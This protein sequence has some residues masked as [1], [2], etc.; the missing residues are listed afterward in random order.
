[1]AAEDITSLLEY[2][3]ST[4]LGGDSDDDLPQEAKTQ[5]TQGLETVL[6]RAKE[7]RQPESL[8]DLLAITQKLATGSRDASWR[9]PIGDS[10]ILD[11]CLDLLAE[12]ETHQSLKIQA[13]R[14][15]GNSCA[16]TDENRAR[17]VDGAYFLPI[18]KLLAEDELVPFVIPSLHNICIEYEPAH[19]KA[20]EAGLCKE[21]AA[22]LQSQRVAKA[23]HL[24]GIAAKTIGLLA[25]TEHEKASSDTSIPITLLQCASS[26]QPWPAPNSP[27]DMEDFIS[28]ISA[29]TAYLT[30]DRIATASASPSDS[31]AIYKSL[32]TA[33]TRF[34]FTDAD[35]DDLDDA[36]QLIN[37]RKALVGIVA[38]LS[39]QPSWTESFSISSDGNPAEWLADHGVTTDWLSKHHSP[40]QEAACLTFG[41]L[42]CDDAKTS[43]LVGTLGI[44]KPLISLL[45]KEYPFQ[46][47][48]DDA[49]PGAVLHSAIGLLKNLA[50]PLGNRPVLGE[51]LLSTVDKPIGDS[52]E[53]STTGL[54]PFI[55]AHKDTQPQTQ[56]A[57]ISLC[58]LLLTGTPSN[59]RLFCEPLPTAASP[60]NT[61]NQPRTQ[62]HALIDVF[63]TAPTE[64]TKTEASRAALALCRVL[65]GSSGGPETTILTSPAWQ[66]PT[67]SSG[68]LANFLAR[69]DGIHDLLAFLLTQTRF[70]A[71]RSEAWFVLALTTRHGSDG[72]PLVARALTSSDEA[73]AAL[74]RAVSLGQ[75]QAAAEAAR[76]TEE[77]K[78]KQ[79]ATVDG[80]EGLGLEPKQAD[81]RQ[82]PQM[83]KIDRENVLVLLVEL[84]KSQAA[85]KVLSEEHKT[86]LQQLMQT[87]GE[88]VLGEREQPEVDA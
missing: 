73:L 11:F 35:E 8:D 85:L 83:A 16:D 10:G 74:E 65:H 22:W 63:T 58:R 67:T 87:G 62:L 39:S 78:Q 88:M 51:Q 56:L 37:M 75:G 24:V 12:P 36:N 60:D 1:M 86:R 41:N 9:I 13:L 28:L 57:T 66:E 4:K 26:P 40:L 2:M 69:H 29:A 14:L 19:A 31:L 18:I 7:L 59:A 68:P 6:A 53:T 30:A 17:V 80:I 20:A 49:A 61:P 52:E 54:L 3:N 76:K 84:L 70:P 79:V 15:A 77:E 82:A 38:D 55:W 48:P 47:G 34:S 5:R 42:A 21:L 46:P 23:P 81:P 45:A 64:P 71:L 72:A 43:W 32:E 44:H 33:C 27:L 25:S 50:I